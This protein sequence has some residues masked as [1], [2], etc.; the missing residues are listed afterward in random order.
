MTTAI[1]QSVCNLVS[2]EPV[3]RLIHAHVTM[4]GVVVFVMYLSVIF[5]VILVE[6]TVLDLIHVHVMLGGPG[7][8]VT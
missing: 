6:G 2:M 5:P 1:W 8:C 7:D 3:C 4:V